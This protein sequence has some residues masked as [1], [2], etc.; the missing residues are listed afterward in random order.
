MF[1]TYLRSLLREMQVRCREMQVLVE[2][3]LLQSPLFTEHLTPGC[4]GCISMVNL[5]SVGGLILTRDE[6][7]QVAK[8]K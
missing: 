2:L 4:S 1:S 7:D 8:V 6:S 5:P 3:G